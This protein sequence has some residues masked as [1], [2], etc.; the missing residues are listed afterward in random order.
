[1]RAMMDKLQIE[2][3]VRFRIDQLFREEGIVIAFPQRDVH[4]DATSP[5]TIQMVD[6]TTDSTP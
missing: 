1:M 4:L 2:S 5:I 3:A 6:H